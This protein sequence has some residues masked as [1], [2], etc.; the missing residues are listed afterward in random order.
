PR[1]MRPHPAVVIVPANRQVRRLARALGLLA[2]AALIL[3]SIVVGGADPFSTLV[4]V[5]FAAVGLVLIARR[6]RERIGWL[7][8][9][10]AVGFVPVGA[11]L[12]GS[13]SEVVAGQASA[14]IT[15]QAWFNSWGASFFY[16]AF[17]TLGAIFPSGRFPDGRLGRIARA[18]VAVPFSFAILLAFAPEVSISFIDGTSATVLNPI[19]LAPGWSGWSVIKAAAI[20]AVFGALSVTIVTFGVRF[21]RARGAEREQH[22]WLLAALGSLL[23]TAGFAFAAILLV[24]PKGT[25][26]WLP[27]LAAYLLIPVSIGIAVTRYRLY[28]IDRIVS[29]TIGW[30]IPSGAILVMFAALVVGLQA[31]LAP[32]TS[33]NTLAVAVSTLAAFA[34]F[35]P[36]RRRIQAMV[37]RR[38]NRARYNADHVVAGLAARLRGE[39]ALDAVVNE[40]ADAARASVAPASARVWLRSHA[41]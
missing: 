10:V 5:S 20:P 3:A 26:M 12:P 7:L 27:V 33:G 36:L 40:V 35:Q 2:L 25:W 37:D 21:R 14:R 17:A 1:T 16:G 23:A 15:A 9:L 34:V 41:G 38:F 30:A 13:A 24:D 39:V 18:A 4:S 11:S 22:K 28:D 31:V 29:R 32:V 8:V 19:G 6:P